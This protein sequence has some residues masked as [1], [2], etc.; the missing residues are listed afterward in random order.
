MTG[1]KDTHFTLLESLS[2]GGANKKERKKDGQG[3][4]DGGERRKEEPSC[5]NPLALSSRD[6]DFPAGAA[7][8]NAGN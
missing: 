6:I 4:D 1:D 7:F 3:Q 2:R 8:V 5:G